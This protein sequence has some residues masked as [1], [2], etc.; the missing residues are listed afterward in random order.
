[1]L[2]CWRCPEYVVCAGMTHAL[3]SPPFNKILEPSVHEQIVLCIGARATRAAILFGLRG[4][5]EL[6]YKAERSEPTIYLE[7]PDL[8]DQAHLIAA[9]L[10]D[11]FNR[12]GVAAH[13]DKRPLSIDA[14]ICEMARRTLRQ[15]LEA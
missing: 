10:L 5:T 3:F 9:N 12:I 4:H 13:P 15:A 1:L 2:E 11:Q 7:T 14:H 6:F 8:I